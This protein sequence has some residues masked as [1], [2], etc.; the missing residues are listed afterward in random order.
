M[1]IT[2]T[3]TPI[4]VIKDSEVTWKIAYEIYPIQLRQAQ[5]IVEMFQSDELFRN[6]N[7]D[8]E[9]RMGCVTHIVLNAE[10]YGVDLTSMPDVL[11]KRMDHLIEVYLAT[12][13]G[14]AAIRA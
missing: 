11:E 2:I 7:I 1:E 10:K 12:N 8:C 13:G 9:Y 5:A 6:I 4:Y 3:E 14:Y